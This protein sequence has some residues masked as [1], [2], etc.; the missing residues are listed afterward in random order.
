MIRSTVNLRIDGTDGVWCSDECA[1]KWQAAN[2]GHY[3][4]QTPWPDLEKESTV[5][6][7]ALARL[8]CDSCGA[9]IALT[10]HR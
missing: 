3:T 2:P 4:K 10:P 1:F 6:R 8:T 9:S 5:R 7:V